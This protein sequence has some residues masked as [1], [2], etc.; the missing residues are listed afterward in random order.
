MFWQTHDVAD[1]VDLARFAPAIFPN[2]R[3]TTKAISLRLPAMLLAELKVLANKRGVPYQ[4]LMKVF[5]AE[6][7]ARER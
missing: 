1:Y 3:P 4:S 5:L 6:S 2:L 7:V